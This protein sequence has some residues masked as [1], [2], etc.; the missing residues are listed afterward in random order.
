MSG[1]IPP[2][3]HIALWRAQELLNFHVNN[4]LPYSQ[5]APSP[6]NSVRG[7][8]SGYCTIGSG[9]RRWENAGVLSYSR[10][11]YRCASCG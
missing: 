8:E 6:V 3:P 11:Y 2:F 7:S 5:R 4:C 9:V 10:R 1:A